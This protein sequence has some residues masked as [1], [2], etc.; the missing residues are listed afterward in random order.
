VSV[1]TALLEEAGVEEPLLAAAAQTR[2]WR[3]HRRADDRSRLT[4]SE[5]KLIEDAVIS[6]QGEHHD[7][8]PV[9]DEVAEQVVERAG[10]Q[11]TVAE[12]VALALKDRRGRA[13]AREAAHRLLAAAGVTPDPEE[14]DAQLADY[15][16]V[17]KNIARVLRRK[18]KPHPAALA[19]GQKD[20]STPTEGTDEQAMAQYQQ[21]ASGQTI[22]EA[23]ID[24][25]AQQIAKLSQQIE[26]AEKEG[27]TDR[28]D[29]LKKKRAAL[30]AQ[31][32]KL[33]PDTFK[34]LEESILP[35]SEAVAGGNVIGKGRGLDM[36]DDGVKALQQRLDE[37]GFQTIHDGRFGIVTEEAVKAFQS[38]HGLAP[39]GKVDETTVA[40]LREPPEQKPKPEPKAEEKQEKPAEQATTEERTEEGDMTDRTEEASYSSGGFDTNTPGRQSYGGLPGV[41]GPGTSSQRMIGGQPEWIGVHLLADPD[42][43]TPG[44][45]DFFGN[46]PVRVPP[47]LREAVDYTF[48]RCGTCVHHNGKRLCAMYSAGTDRDDLCDSWLT[49]SPPQQQI[50]AAF[51]GRAVGQFVQ[52]ATAAN[53]E[54]LKLARARLEEAVAESG[55]DEL[56][57]MVKKLTGK[58]IPLAAAKKMATKALARKRAQ[59]AASGLPGVVMLSEAEAHRKLKCPK[60]DHVQSAT[61]KTCT[62][63]GHDLADARKAK[64][65]Q[66]DESVLDEDGAAEAL[67]EWLLEEA[68]L[69]A[70]KRKKLSKS[71]FAIPEDEAY[72]I[73]DESHARNALARVSQHGTP[74]EKKRVRS[75]VKKKHPHLVQE[76]AWLV[77]VKSSAY[78]G[79]ERVPGKQNWVDYAG[80]LPDYI[81]RIAKHIHYE[82]GK[83]IGTAIAMAVGTVKRWCRGGEVAVSAKGGVSKTHGVSA[84]TKAKACA[85]LASWEAKRKAGSAVKE[86][87]TGEDVGVLAVRRACVEALSLDDPIDDMS[88]Q[89]ALRILHEVEVMEAAYPV[90]IHFDPRLHPR[91]RQGEFRDILG[92]LMK[93]T[94]GAE[95]T[96]PNGVTVKRS[97]GGRALTVARGGKKLGSFS[98]PEAAASKALKATGIPNEPTIPSYGKQTPR[99]AIAF[100]R[101]S[102]SG[103]MKGEDVVKRAV[104][105]AHEPLI[106]KTLSS[107]S[108]TPG[109]TTIYSYKE[110]LAHVDHGSREVHLNVHRYSTTSTQHR[111]MV[112]DAA[113]LAGY[114]IRKI[115]RNESLS[116]VNMEP[117]SSF[118]KLPS[119]VKPDPGTTA[120][121]SGEWAQRPG[122][123]NGVEFHSRELPNGRSETLHKLP[124]WT[125][126]RHMTFTSKGSLGQV[127]DLSNKDATKLLKGETGGY[128]HLQGVGRHPAMKA[129]EVKPGHQRVY[130]FGHTAEVTGV[131]VQ[132]GKHDFNRSGGTVRITTRH[133]DGQERTTRHKA[134]TLIPVTGS[135]TGDRRDSGLKADMGSGSRDL[136][137]YLLGLGTGKHEIIANGVPY[138]L[139]YDEHGATGDSGAPVRGDK[140]GEWEVFHGHGDQIKGQ[141]V[142]R[143]HV[144]PHGTS[145]YGND[146]APRYAA[147]EVARKLTAH[148]REHAGTKADT[149]TGKWSPKVGDK[150]Q[151]KQATRPR[152]AGYG[153]NPEHTIT[154]DMVGTVTHAG[155]DPVR[156][157]KKFNIA[158]FEGLKNEKGE[159]LPGHKGGWQVEFQPNEVTPV[160]GEKSDTGVF[161]QHELKI[162]R[163]TLKMHPA[164]AGVMGGP[165]A[166]TAFESVK[167]LTGKAPTKSQM[168]PANHHLLGGGEKADPGSGGE[169]GRIVSGSTG[170][171]LT[172]PGHPDQRYSIE[173]DLRRKP[174]NRSSM[175]LSS[176]LEPN[177]YLDAVTKAK[178]AGIMRDYK[179]NQPPLDH[180]ATQ[181]WIRSTL[182]YFKGM[183]HDP[184]LPEGER[185][186]V[187]NLRSVPEA[188]PMENANFHAGVHFVRRYY[189]DYQP[190][191]EHFEPGGYG[192]KDHS[193]WHAD[194]ESHS[195]LVDKAR[196]SDLVTMS[197]KPGTTIHRVTGTGLYRN[198]THTVRQG[199]REKV[200][201]S[202]EQAA[203]WARDPNFN[204]DEGASRNHRTGR[205]FLDGQEREGRPGDT[206][207]HAVSGEKADLG[208]MRATG[209]PHDLSEREKNDLAAEVAKASR[210]AGSPINA[211]HARAEVDLWIAQGRD[212]RGILQHY[213]PLGVEKGDPGD[214]TT[215]R[216]QRPG[217][218]NF[219]NRPDGA[220]LLSQITAGTRVTIM[221]PHGQE[222]TGRAVMRSSHGGWVLNMGGAHGTP[223]LVD[224][225]NIVRVGRKRKLREVAAEIVA[226]KPA[227]KTDPSVAP[228]LKADEAWPVR[229]PLAEALVKHKTKIAGELREELLDHLLGCAPKEETETHL[230]EARE[231]KN[232]AKIKLYETLLSA[233]S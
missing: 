36:P 128:V 216:F 147:E 76:A 96:M 231:E 159:P 125:G 132:G 173:T 156:G 65:A 200:A 222:R 123:V 163:D 40:A 28:T 83:P 53:A 154:P 167:R 219:P 75:A 162:A 34:H 89:D 211:Y 41:V 45:D 145:G 99:Y 178:A 193:V 198:A 171:F 8:E 67:Q 126:Y 175:S 37:L 148:M 161:D 160:G 102:G 229:L 183:Y 94:Q 176:A 122:G 146:A 174:E 50:A 233:V 54:T 166:A 84:A 5:S 134:D 78:P 151:L 85:A 130:N 23:D 10:H 227:L 141:A 165:D 86:A 179:K 150:I 64:F 115:D 60:C 104:A 180:P 181:E 129:S 80:G 201:Y 121:P 225:R 1:L 208:F 109:T 79:L 144:S 202:A 139:Y 51:Y 124:G 88:Q 74:E 185:A 207:T 93:A 7:G 187:S 69:T 195:A 57:A 12:G 189:P 71:D 63:C 95:V 108:H 205:E 46:E 212:P 177:S 190:Q 169:R 117:G 133:Q 58:G 138:T 92:R 111:M 48:E 220:E 142:A 105:G 100:E 98:K 44:M 30:I 106:G 172:P 206:V 230:Q 114:K 6:L 214:R 72:P 228:L 68:P 25:I 52:E 203:K 188:D 118:S 11:A 59:E 47:N 191:P 116:R 232:A 131:E 143:V 70:E 164:M 120:G 197:D 199:H 87:A 81:E 149:G 97:R 56:D 66:M 107:V 103:S 3:R 29:E 73:H 43:R 4:L 16:S 32:K 26:A 42:D 213:H 113:H 33:A 226:A 35:L 31:G 215:A 194:V 82:H 158:R 135:P 14:L 218:H 27:Q 62:N 20:S 153:A 196:N 209:L 21:D 22:V 77:E 24:S 223:G 13:R 152:Y 110:P 221:T 101:P 15:I 157:R 55:G 136:P 168:H 91:N 61:N 137:S 17:H 39:T 182:G 112:E 186:K 127:T 119:G 9:G 170:S 204:M 210:K 217:S 192:Q 184:N 224:E 19:I 155:V 38:K 18:A 140:T 2:N 90:S 49:L